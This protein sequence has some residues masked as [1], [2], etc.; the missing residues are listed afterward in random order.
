MNDPQTKK[1]FALISALSETVEQLS[2]AVGDMQAAINQ[3]VT[4]SN[5]AVANSQLVLAGYQEHGGEIERLSRRVERLRFKCPLMK[6]TE[7]NPKIDC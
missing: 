5:Q 3:T 6:D 4:N 2:Q 1:L 7:E